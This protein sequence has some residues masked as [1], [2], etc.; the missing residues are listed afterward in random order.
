[1]TAM[2]D[3]QDV[4]PAVRLGLPV[5]AMLLGWAVQIGYSVYTFY[6]MLNTT[7]TSRRAGLGLVAFIYYATFLAL[8]GTIWVLSRFQPSKPKIAALSLLLGLQALTGLGLAALRWI[9]PATMN[10]PVLPWTW[11]S[12]VQVGSQLLIG[13][14]A[15]WGLVKLQPWRLPP[16]SREPVSP[17]ARRAQQLFGLSGIVGV[18]AVMVL[19]FGI[20]GYDG[21][22][23]G[24]LR[25][26]HVAPAIAII[27]IAIWLLAMAL[28]WW[29]Y[30]NADEH[31]RKAN[32]IGFL[33]G[34]GLFMALT[35]A[36]WI[37]SRAALAPPP[38]AVIIWITSM[39]V[40][41]LGWGWYR[42][43]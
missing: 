31:E 22:D 40:M 16:R 17:S 19:L 3:E 10:L 7:P 14:G 21:I 37:A 30:A 9:L 35:P 27:V 11:Q 15:V 36:W 13:V 43:R 18:L 42:T 34:G 41:G 20:A 23:L 32:D 5:L 29:W 39:L 33:I 1:M 26:R 38:D 28:A 4:R 2:N 24:G 25:S 12:I 8:I 6:Y